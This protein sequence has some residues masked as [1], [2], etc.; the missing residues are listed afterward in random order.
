MAKRNIKQYRN[1]PQK[2]FKSYLI[3]YI[4]IKET[5]ELYELFIKN[6]Y[7]KYK[8]DKYQRKDDKA[9]NVREHNDKGDIIITKNLAGRETDL[10]LKKYKT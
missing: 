5:D 10:K 2:I 8:I 3:I 9:N 1:I 6:I 4:T 7:K